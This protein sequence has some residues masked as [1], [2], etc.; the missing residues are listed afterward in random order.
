MIEDV[1]DALRTIVRRDALTGSDVDV[2]FDAP[3]VDLYLYDIREDLQRREVM[4]Q[5]IRDQSTGFVTEHRPPPRYYKLSYLVTA[6]TQR[7]EDEHRLLSALLSCFIRHERLPDDV[8]TGMLVGDLP[9]FATIA[10]PP[11]SDRP[12]SDIWSALGGELKPSL[13][14]VI[15]APLVDGR[16]EVAGPPV[17]EE[18]RISVRR[19]RVGA[20]AAGGIGAGGHDGDEAAA[21]GQPGE[22]GGQAGGRRG[23]GAGAAGAG[24]SAAQDAGTA[25]PAGTAGAEGQAGTV[26]GAPGAPSGQSAAAAGA[27]PGQ[28]L[29]DETVTSGSEA[30]PGR[31][32]RLHVRRPPR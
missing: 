11:P 31:V 32:V 22:G 19:P 20:Q 24:V 8:L 10:L 29:P 7:P 21:A 28:P 4:W 3:T 12:L 26:P 27:R 18:P 30:H 6:W 1:D 17:R 14:L 23:R 25:A 15:T 16:E 13:D 9:I 5:A 2:A